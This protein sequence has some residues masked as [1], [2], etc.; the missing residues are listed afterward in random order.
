MSI[1]LISYSSRPSRNESGWSELLGEDVE[2][3]NLAWLCHD[4][5]KGHHR[6]P[7]F[8]VL[9]RR[10]LQFVIASGKIDL[11]DAYPAEAKVRGLLRMSPAQAVLKF[12]Q[13]ALIRDLPLYAAYGEAWLDIMRARSRLYREPHDQVLDVELGDFTQANNAISICK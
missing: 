8:T 2:A 7:R 5:H 10:T 4:S 6:D 3:C 11:I 13:M 1:A 9:V 12:S